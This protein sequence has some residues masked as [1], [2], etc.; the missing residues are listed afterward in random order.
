MGNH[1][2]RTSNLAGLTSQSFAN[3]ANDRLTTDTFDANGNTTQGSAPASS[4]ADGAPP[5]PRTSAYDAE[6][7]LA[8]A[9]RPDGTAVQVVYD[10]DSH[11]SAASPRSA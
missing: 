4:V 10:G 5:A 6:N 9:T 8:N 2:A 7:R 3:D 11:G 1:L